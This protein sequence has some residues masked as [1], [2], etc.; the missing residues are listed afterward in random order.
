MKH[1]NCNWIRNWKEVGL[2]TEKGQSTESCLTLISFWSPLSVCFSPLAF[3]VL[4]CWPSSGKESLLLWFQVFTQEFFRRKLW[5]SR[6]LRLFF[7]GLTTKCSCRTSLL[8]KIIV[9]FANRVIRGLLLWHLLWHLRY[10]T[11]V[12]VWR[13]N[14][15]SSNFWTRFTFPCNHLCITQ[16]W[17]R[18]FLLE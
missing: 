10:T 11:C 5:M 8:H 16:S 18:L 2:Y 9:C 12:L 13:S 6:G 4:F 14:G 15:R 7:K 1:F 3:T 17:C